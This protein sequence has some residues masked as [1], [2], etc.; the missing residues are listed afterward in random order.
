MPQA[1]TWPR[2]MTDDLYRTPVRTVQKNLHT[3]VFVTRADAQTV[4]RIVLTAKFERGTFSHA[5]ET[6]IVNVDFN[7]RWG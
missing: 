5:A 2:Y 7:I 3:V 6:A 1:P 4:Q